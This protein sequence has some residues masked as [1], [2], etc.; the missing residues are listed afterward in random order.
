MTQII[1]INGLQC[2][3]STPLRKDRI[4]YILYPMEVLSDWIEPASKKYGTTI[5]VITGMDWQNVFSPWPAKGVPAGT[6]DF[7]GESPEFLKELETAVIPQLEKV[8]EMDKNVDRTL[9]GVSMS[10][11]FTLWQW[12]QSSLFKNIASL[13]GSFWY[14]GFMEWFK[15]QEFTDKKGFAFFLLGL[16]E[17]KSNVKAFNIVGENTEEIVK[18]LKE[19]GVRVE[20]TWVPGNHYQNGI[21]RLDMAMET[22]KANI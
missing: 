9:V 3:C 13:S 22:V 10:G 7:K 5:V 6:E 4:T 19:A 12:P 15:K 14:E 18:D 17:P 1:E 8:L 20:F 21:Q 16:Q 11:L 2:R